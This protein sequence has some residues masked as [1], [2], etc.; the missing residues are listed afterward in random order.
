MTKL[1]IQIDNE[2]REMTDEEYAQHLINIQGSE[3]N[4]VGI[5]ENPFPIAEIPAV[6]ETPVTDEPVVD[7]P[8]V[9]E[10]PVVDDLV[11]GEQP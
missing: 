11:E 2:L 4:Y 9:E 10:T 6:D 5:V 1:F 3:A 8:V 7:E